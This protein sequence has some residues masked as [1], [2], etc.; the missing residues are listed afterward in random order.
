MIPSIIVLYKNCFPRCFAFQLLCPS[1]T[2]QSHSKNLARLLYFPFSLNL[3]FLSLCN[4]GWL[5]DGRGSGLHQKLEGIFMR[6]KARTGKALVAKV[7]AGNRIIRWIPR[8]D[9]SP[10]SLGV[11]FSLVTS[12]R[13]VRRRNGCG[14]GAE[15]RRDGVKWYATAESCCS[16]L[17]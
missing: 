4:L 12:A 8:S 3:V 5:S 16:P 6:T 2:C 13:F 7:L 1:G 9:G 14:C 11:F 15:M 10:C 17:C